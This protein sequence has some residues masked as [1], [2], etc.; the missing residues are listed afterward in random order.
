VVSL[1]IKYADIYRAA[2]ISLCTNYRYELTRTW[3]RSKKPV[4]FVM[5]NPSTADSRID[6]P[7]IRR[8]MGFAQAWGKG[9]IIVVN[10][11]A[12]RATDPRS[13]YKLAK[14]EAVGPDNDR[15]IVAA[16]LRADLHVAAWGTH[17]RLCGRDREVVELANHA[18]ISNGVGP[19]MTALKA[20]KNGDPMHPLYLR[21]DL[22]PTIALA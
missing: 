5:L 20:T 3:D 6:D 10:L 14:A 12:W 19:G 21:A 11:F 16:C 17:G 7:T 4:L 2:V 8:C 9:G 18:I 15:H 13:L 22:E 1:T